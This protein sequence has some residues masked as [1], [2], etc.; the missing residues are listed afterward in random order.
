MLR[1]HA[2]GLRSNSANL[3]SNGRLHSIISLDCAGLPGAHSADSPGSGA[4]PQEGV[5]QPAWLP[6]RMLP[7]IQY[8]ANACQSSKEYH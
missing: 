3:V 4:H 1:A 2:G 6:E 5:L 7:L 8:Q